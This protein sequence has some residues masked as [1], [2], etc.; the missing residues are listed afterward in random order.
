MTPYDYKNERVVIKNCHYPQYNGKSTLI[1]EVK[2]TQHGYRF[3]TELQHP[4]NPEY[5][6]W[7]FENEIDYIKQF[8]GVLTQYQSKDG[9][10]ITKD[11]LNDEN[12]LLS[13]VGQFDIY[14]KNYLK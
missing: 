3:K 14:E 2:Y 5:D 8:K 10:I 9:K 12:G 1:V 6:L 7:L 13:I 11:T 4:T